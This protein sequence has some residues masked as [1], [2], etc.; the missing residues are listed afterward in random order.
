[1]AEYRK[2]DLTA[3]TYVNLPTLQLLTALC[4]LAVSTHGYA[5]QWFVN[6][7][8]KIQPEYED[9]VRLRPDGNDSTFGLTGGV[10]VEA[11]KASEVMEIAIQGL[12]E[13]TTY[14]ESDVPDDG[15]ASLGLDYSLKATER[16]EIDLDASF[17]N[18]S[19]LRT[20]TNEII[21]PGDIDPGISSFRVRRNKLDISPAWTYALTERSGVELGYDF[22][23][24]DYG[25]KKGRAG[26]EDYL[27]HNGL[28]RVFY[29]L[30][31]NTTVSGTLEGF[32]YSSS[33]SDGESDGVLLLAGIE[34]RFSETLFGDLAGG[35]YTT[36]V[37]VDSVQDS[38][39][40]ALFSASLV[41]RLERTRLRALVSRDLLPSGS[42]QV[43]EAD[44]LVFS[45]KYE[46][47]PRLDFS[48]RTR[49]LK[50][51]NI[52]TANSNK[53]EFIL[54]EPSL[55]WQL[56]ERLD[57]LAVYRYRYRDDKT[58]G[59]TADSNRVFVSLVYKWPGGPDTR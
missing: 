25:N 5:Q 3:N 6:S 21:D 31:E 56:S 22:R 38:E 34:H 10:T 18:D 43:R 39:S 16:S 8:A 45:V 41:K 36:D 49:F 54:A 15:F 7:S 48:F 17:V 4:L 33:D 24:V 12:L 20:V 29:R 13:G 59:D 27:Y 57:L 52:G 51:E 44:Q 42:G 26:L 1:M 40:G 30:T 46:V 58:I 11:Q 14:S 19:T 47:T 23:G 50:T 2:I 32:H 28:G 37:D 55:V 53:R 35:G 9:N